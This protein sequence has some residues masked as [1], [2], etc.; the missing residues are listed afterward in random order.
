MLVV[1]ST[2]HCQVASEAH[3]A[4]GFLAALRC[5]QYV[6]T[7]CGCELEAFAFLHYHSPVAGGMAKETVNVVV[8]RIGK[9]TYW[10]SL[11]AH[12]RVTLCATTRLRRFRG[13]LR[14]ENS[15]P[16]V[17]D[18]R[19]GRCSVAHHHS[20][21]LVLRPVFQKLRL[22]KLLVVQAPCDFFCGLLMAGD[23]GFRALVLGH[24]GGV[25]RRSCRHQTCKK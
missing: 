22:G 3:L 15:Y 9:L 14:L 25:I 24:E 4:G 1:R 10:V 19:V 6:H 5:F 11:L 21:G 18:N 13:I 2:A 7:G 20:C 23:A 8:V 17:P 16:V 12:S